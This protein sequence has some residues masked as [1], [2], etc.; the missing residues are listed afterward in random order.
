MIQLG[1]SIQRIVALLAD[2]HDLQHPFQF[3]KFDAKDGF[4]RLIVNEDEAWNFC[5]VLPPK[6]GHKTT[7]ID[8]VEL[9]VPLSIQ[10]GW[11]ESPPYFCTSSETSR[12]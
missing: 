3:A 2:Y 12:D 4:W 11:T 6:E 1:Q 9:D 7:N 5:Y 10:I 8:E